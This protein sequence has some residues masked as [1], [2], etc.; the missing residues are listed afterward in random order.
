M[1]PLWYAYYTLVPCICLDSKQEN[2]DP[3][4]A[5]KNLPSLR[6]F[7]ANIARQCGNIIKCGFRM[8]SD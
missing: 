1:Y 4:M 7:P 8:R 3:G 6:N 2:K 5:S